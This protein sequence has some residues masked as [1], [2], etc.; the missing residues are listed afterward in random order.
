MSITV[1]PSVRDRIIEAQV[2]AVLPGNYVNEE[3]NGLEQ[4]FERK[5][6]NGLYLVV[7]L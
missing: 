5:N 2:N 4:Q 1:I 3:L 6:D 7:R